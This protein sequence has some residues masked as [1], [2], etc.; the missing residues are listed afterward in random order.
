MTSEAVP[1]IQ[2]MEEDILAKFTS[3]I[4]K[5]NM[6]ILVKPSKMP[7]EMESPFLDISSMSE[8]MKMN[9]SSTESFKQHS[10]ITILK[11]MLVKYHFP[12]LISFVATLKIISE[13]KAV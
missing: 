1:N 9:P 7:K 2:S 12:C 10:K 5:M 8:M 13:M 11:I 3:S 6:T 4:T